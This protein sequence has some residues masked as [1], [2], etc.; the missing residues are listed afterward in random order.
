ME[1]LAKRLG[2][3]IEDCDLV[4]NLLGVISLPPFS[5]SPEFGIIILNS[6]LKKSPLERDFTIAHEM[7]HY[8]CNHTGDGFLGGK[9]GSSWEREWEADR[10]AWE[11]ISRKYNPLLGMPLQSVKLTRMIEEVKSCFNL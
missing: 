8:F 5:K 7:G 1:K 9:G 2:F 11:L 10:F 4:D 3:I 6:I